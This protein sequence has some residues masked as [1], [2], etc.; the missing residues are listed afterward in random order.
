MF[1]E[2]MLSAEENV[3]RIEE[4]TLQELKQTVLN[5]SCAIHSLSESIAVLDVICSLAKQA[6]GDGYTLPQIN[7]MEPAK[8]CE[9]IKESIEDIY[10]CLDSFVVYF[11]LKDKE[12][13][14]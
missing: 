12:Q 10:K 2:K 14:K 13:V 5:H 9:I 1:E 6:R 11:G 8:V 7:D 3:L 4:K